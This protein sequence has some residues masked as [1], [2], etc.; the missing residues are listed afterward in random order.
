MRSEFTL[1]GV[2]IPRPAGGLLQGVYAH[3]GIARFWGAQRRVET[4]PDN[5]L[6]AE[7]TF[8][9]W[10]SMIEPTADTLLGAGCLT[11]VGTKFVAT[12]R[13]EGRRLASETV[14]ADARVI[15]RDVSLDHWLTWQLRH[16]AIDPI[17]TADLAAAYQA[18]KPLADGA[19]P[20][21]RIEEETRKVDPAARSR[22][23]STRF[24]RPHRYR[25]LSDAGMPGLSRAD[26]FLMSGQASM[27]V[28]AYR[29]E[30]SAASEPL[31]DAWLGLALA[32]HLLAGTP[33]L[34][35]FATRLPL[36]FDLHASL[37]AQG[38]RSDPLELAAWLA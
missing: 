6:R 2:R 29:D 24:L 14:P 38:V 26:R 17:A 35:A 7:V 30:I 20:E 23:L 16:G 12:L 15:A 3:L 27:A 31:P 32:V 37:F 18:G 28:H 36:M 1:R 25:E 13:D 19:L 9:R 21:V 11:P 5:I 34:S 33:L 10:R 8:E 22:L 4:E